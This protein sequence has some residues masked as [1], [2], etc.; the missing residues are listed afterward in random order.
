[1][2]AS[3]KRPRSPN[4]ECEDC[5]PISKRINRLQ[6]ESGQ[7]SFS[8]DCCDQMNNNIGRPNGNVHPDNI[9]T[10][11][12]KLRINS[13][14]VNPSHLRNSAEFPGCSGCSQSMVES[15]SMNKLPFDMSEGYNPE[16]R[17]KE[18]PIY[19][20]INQVLFDA[21]KERAERSQTKFP[22]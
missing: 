8:H 3:L 10:Q 16:L 9:I 14:P 6:I 2:T 11:C 22:D 15:Q 17:E 21:H 4:A 1:M 5:L 19:F 7:Q 13:D 20:Q 18:N 12:R